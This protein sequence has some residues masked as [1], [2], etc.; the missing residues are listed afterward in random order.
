[1]NLKQLK[2]G[3]EISEILNR[4]NEA[5]NKL[6]GIKPYSPKD[7]KVLEDGLYNFCISEHRDGSGWKAELSRYFG[8]VR[9]LNV[10]IAELEKQVK[11]L[12]EQYDK[13]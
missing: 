12:Q 8:N 1:M 10:I 5:L 6:K 4:T 9:L 3:H 7:G 13:L 11:E 2:E